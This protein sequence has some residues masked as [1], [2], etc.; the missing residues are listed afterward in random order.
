MMRQFPG[1]E[2]SRNG[3]I[4]AQGQVVNRV[5]VNG[6]DFFTG[7]VLT[8]TRNLPANIVENIQIID[9]YG[10]QANRTGFKNTDPERIINI[11]LKKDKNRGMFGQVTGGIGTDY[12]Y[13]GSVSANSFDDTQQF[14]V[15]GSTNNTNASLFSFGDISGAGTRE[16]GGS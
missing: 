13:L 16:R 7:D 3:R 12:R 8:A 14:S 11:T 6:K 5:K 9:D 4:T 1:V 15:L 10:E 2:I